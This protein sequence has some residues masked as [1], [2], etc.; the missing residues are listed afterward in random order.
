[1][2]KKDH[3]SDEPTPK[4]KI[5]DRRHLDDV[6]PEPVKAPPV[7]EKPAPVAPQQEID[8]DPVLHVESSEE[9]PEQGTET[10]ESQEDPL[11]FRNVTLSF[12]QTLSTISWVHLGLV[13]HPQTQLMLKKL[14]EA[15]KT[16]ALFEVIF[17]QAKVDFPPE[18]NKEIA[19]LLN[20]LKAHYVNQL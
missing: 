17:N 7:D 12:L 13:P 20:D 16:I 2:S 1:L 5:V 19:G 8:K 4:F 15:R 3:Q 10:P 11:G 6:E 18:I 9:V 14:D